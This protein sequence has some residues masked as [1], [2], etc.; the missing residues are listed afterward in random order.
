[1][2]PIVIKWVIG[3]V[4]LAGV[5]V[6]AGM[7]LSG[8]TAV[9][10]VTVERRAIQQSVV[11]TGRVNAPA[12][13]DLGAEVTATVTEVRAREGDRVAAGTLL[14][15]L[16]DAEAQATLEQA[17]GALAEARLRARQQAGVTRPVADQ[18][19][20]QAEVV[21]TNAE[22][23]LQRARELVA[24]GFF[25]QQKL[26]EAQRQAD[27]ARSALDA[28]R[29]QA[30]AQQARGVEPVLAASRVEQA[31]AALA[32]AQARLTRLRITSPIDAVVLTRTVEPGSLAQP[33][34]VLMS[35]A[36]ARGVRV[37][38]NV[39][40]KHLRTLALG[41][42]GRVVADAV[43]AQAFDARLNY[44]APAVDPLRG[45]VEVR[46]EVPTPPAFL[47]P[48]MTVSVE[49]LG[50]ARADALVLPAAAVRDADRDAPWVL[51]LRDGR[52]VR[53]PV[54]VG[55]SGVGAIEITEGLSP[56]DQAIPQTE[57]ALPGDRVRAAAPRGTEKGMEVPSFI[58]R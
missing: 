54:R 47:R 38:A 36:A 35:L 19:V 43:P 28:A 40:E 15:R 14:L 25:S 45:S 32:A 42:P 53:V 21:T 31:E 2:K 13:I 33:G 4:V 48:D 58:S 20:R 6:L 7:R 11:V 16:S 26:D 37:D 44:I 56:G 10:V 18:A 55:L 49:L 29:V 1:M 22:R 41:M 52:A 39:D 12:R 24:Q 30:Q 46:L 34:K 57:K 51:A 17:R 23:E 8:G 9:Q 5:V 27:T 50:G 3:A